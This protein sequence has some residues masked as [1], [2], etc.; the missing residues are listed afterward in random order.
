[1]LQAR[2]SFV[3]RFEGLNF[4]IRLGQMVKIGLRT[5][6][7]CWLYYVF[8][9]LIGVG[10]IDNIAGFSQFGLVKRRLITIW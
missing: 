9:R 5:S 2:G 1:M 10:G 6:L 3:A 7:L 4:S 8:L